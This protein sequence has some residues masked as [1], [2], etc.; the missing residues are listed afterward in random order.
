MINYHLITIIHIIWSDSS[1]FPN[2]FTFTLGTK[3]LPQDFMFAETQTDTWTT[4]Y[5]IERMMNETN[6]FCYSFY[7]NFFASWM[8]VWCV[9][10]QNA[11]FALFR[12]ELRC[13]SFKMFRHDI[14]DT[15]EKNA[16]YGKWFFFGNSRIEL[17]TTDYWVV[18]ISILRLF[19]F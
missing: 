6:F 12:L 19:Y 18:A 7:S 14:R 13:F 17:P 1:F 8:F 9:F 2:L 15:N 11:D 5:I 3:R 10:V 4:S 16:M